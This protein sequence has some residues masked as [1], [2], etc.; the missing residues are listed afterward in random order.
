MAASE[1][2]R[3]E[4]PAE[5]APHAGAL[6]VLPDV[7]WD[8]EPVPV[9]ANFASIGSSDE[10]FAIVFGALSGNGRKTPA[11]RPV[12]RLVSSIRV[13]PATFYRTLT[14]MISIWN[15]WVER[16]GG[17]KDAPRFVQVSGKEGD[18]K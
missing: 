15:T 8:T 5:G 2:K 9:H 4:R 7:D 13:S 18:S 16:D 14:A 11:G 12:G 1:G 6:N 3:S 17:P 10:D